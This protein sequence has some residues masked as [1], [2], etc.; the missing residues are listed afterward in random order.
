[1]N[2][3]GFVVMLA[4]AVVV[5]VSGEPP[6]R[7]RQPFSRGFGRLQQDPAFA[8]QTAGYEYPK[9]AGY[10]YPQPEQPFPLP[11]EELPAYTT[12]VAPTTTAVPTTELPTTTAAVDDYDDSVTE[13]PETETVEAEAVAARLRSARLRQA[14]RNS[15]RQ[16][17]GRLEALDNQQQNQEQQRP[18]YLVNIPESTLQRLVLL[19]QAQVAAPV[20]AAAPLAAAPFQFAPLTAAAPLQAANPAAFPFAAAPQQVF[21]TDASGL[22]YA[23]K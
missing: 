8:R 3:F 12:T 20:A 6:V 15:N 18:I 23:K 1:M 13:D 17:L 4:L 9:P 16:R 22:V 11:E 14:P 2:S 7:Y 10:S 5:S 21:I 19:N